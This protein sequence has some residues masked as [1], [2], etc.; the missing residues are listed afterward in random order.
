MKQ[1]K[2]IIRFILSFFRRKKR[3]PFITPTIEYSEIINPF[4][5]ATGQVFKFLITPKYY[6]EHFAKN[7]KRTNKRK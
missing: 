4:C 7:H 5:K 2:E 3:D 1:L 6:G